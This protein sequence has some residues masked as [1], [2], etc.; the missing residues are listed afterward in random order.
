VRKTR[1]GEKM[2]Y[3]LR[4]YTLKPNELKDFMRFY[5]EKALPIIQRVLQGRGEFVGHWITK[6]REFAD[7]KGGINTAKDIESERRMIEEVEVNYMLAFDDEERH[8]EYWDEFGRE[9]ARYLS[10]W[11]S[12]CSK[13]DD[14]VLE[15]TK[16]HPKKIDSHYVLIFTRPIDS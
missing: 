10:E 5:G 6:S 15:M 14:R 11:S 13:I 16:Y 1:K 2:I 3:D 7:I 4:C 12:M 8:D 9:F